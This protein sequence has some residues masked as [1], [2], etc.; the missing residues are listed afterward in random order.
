[1]DGTR[2][3]VQAHLERLG[4]ELADR[5]WNATIGLQDGGPVLL[6]RNPN[7]ADLNEQIL[8]SGEAFRWTWGQGIGPI[9]EVPGV[10][11]RIM[12]VLR[13]VEE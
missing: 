11:A 13:E 5:G 3:D 9:T 2:I 7:V 8:C 1:M 6:V 10:A 12:H 4:A